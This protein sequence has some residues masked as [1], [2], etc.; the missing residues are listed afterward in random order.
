MIETLDKMIDSLEEGLR[1]FRA[2]PIMKLLTPRPRCEWCG[3]PIGDKF[4]A[5][6]WA[7]D[8]FCDVSCLYNYQGWCE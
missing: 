3:K 1:E 7:G 5:M 6:R 8:Y 2:N 4:G